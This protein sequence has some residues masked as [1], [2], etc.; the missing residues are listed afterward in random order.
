MDLTGSQSTC[1]HS[2]QSHGGG[3][4]FQRL[5]MTSN[6]RPLQGVPIAQILRSTANAKGTVE[7]TRL[8]DP[9]GLPALGAGL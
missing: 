8:R 5:G 2:S 3:V 1:L 9:P 6:T 7:G 4:T